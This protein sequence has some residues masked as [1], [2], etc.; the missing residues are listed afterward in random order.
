MMF[1]S[2]MQPI[3]HTKFYKFWIP[4]KFF[5]AFLKIIKHELLQFNDKNQVRSYKNIVLFWCAWSFVKWRNGSNLNF[6]LN[7]QYK[8]VFSKSFIERYVGP[9]SLVMGVSIFNLILHL[10]MLIVGIQYNSE[11]YCKLEVSEYIPWSCEQ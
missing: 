11:E 7:L 9:W 10:S 2:I 5:I 3:L 8:M 1:W 4:W 6:S